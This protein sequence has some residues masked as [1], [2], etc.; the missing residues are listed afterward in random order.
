LVTGPLTVTDSAT[1]ATSTTD[2]VAT[3]NTKAN[4]ISLTIDTAPAPPP[5]TAVIPGFNNG[6][7]TWETPASGGQDISKY[8]IT[9]TPLNGQPAVAGSP[10]TVFVGPHTSFCTGA[11]ANDCYQL[12]VGGLQNDQGAYR[13][14]VRAV[15]AVDPSDPA[16][17]TATP[18]ADA[19]NASIAAGTAKTLTTCTTATPAHPVCVQYIIPSGGVGGVFG[20]E[21]NVSLAQNPNL[22]PGGCSG[23]GSQALASLAGYN[24]RTH[25]LTEIITFDAKQ[26]STSYARAPLCANNSTSLNCYPNNVQF[27]AEMSFALALPTDPGGTLLNAH[28]CSVSVALGGAGSQNYARPDPHNGPY[29]GF[30]D[31]PGHGYT[32]TAGSAC[33]KKVN[34]LG[35]KPDAS[36]NGDVQIQVNLT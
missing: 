36:A 34:V 10:F 7:L 30:N 31:T 26:I 8:T 18:S 3:N 11:Q 13:F 20:A 25:P 5:N 21:G 6:I 1:V 12:T 29:L 27:Y 17:V 35:S 14:D 16:S 9:V 33:L 28:F 32:D 19:Q 15:N 23:T 24:D 2:Y 22:C 4:A